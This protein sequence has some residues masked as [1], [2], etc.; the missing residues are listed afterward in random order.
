VYDMIGRGRC[1]SFDCS[2]SFDW[3]IS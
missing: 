1:N 3:Q 2:V